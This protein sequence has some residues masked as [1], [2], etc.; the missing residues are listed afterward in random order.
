MPS[1]TPAEPDKHVNSTEGNLMTNT[2]SP[3][4]DRFAPAPP[5]P[6]EGIRPFGLSVA[7]WDPL[8]RFDRDQ[9]SIDSETQIGMVG[10]RPLREDVITLDYPVD[11]K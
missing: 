8:A 2:M 7:R 3:E 9:V 1:K 10:D 4:T 6:R 5:T 11:D